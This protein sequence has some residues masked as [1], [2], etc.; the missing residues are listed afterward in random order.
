DRLAASCTR[1]SRPP[2]L[3][4]RHY[5]QTQRSNRSALWLW[6]RGCCSAGVAAAAEAVTF[7]RRCTCEGSDIPRDL[8]SSSDLLILVVVSPCGRFVVVGTGLE[9]TVEDVDKSVS[10]SLRDDPA[11]D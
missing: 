11:F 10:E 1:T 8:L 7:I 5:R 2:E 9:A 6:C 4:R 3:H